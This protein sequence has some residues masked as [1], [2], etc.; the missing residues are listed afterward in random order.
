[1]RVIIKKQSMPEVKTGN[2]K[3]RPGL[4]VYLIWPTQWE[5]SRV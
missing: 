3:V 5:G 4:K 1:M 2:P